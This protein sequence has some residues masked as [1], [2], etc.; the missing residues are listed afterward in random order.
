[1]PP[2]GTVSMCEP[3]N[4]TGAAAPIRSAPSAPK[5]LP[6][7]STHV[8]SPAAF[9]SPSSHARASSCGA[10]QHIRVTPPPGSAPKR[11][12]ADKRSRSRA[13]DMEG[14]GRQYMP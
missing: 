5:T 6:A 13:R 14:T 12:S 10:L 9:S 1:M 7:G 3:V 2:S 8:V 11:A 4:T